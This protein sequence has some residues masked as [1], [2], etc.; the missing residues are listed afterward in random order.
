MKEN[1]YPARNVN[2]WII[3]FNEGREK[4]NEKTK[5]MVEKRKKQK[6]R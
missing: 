6:K 2:I 4:F 3:T 5:V 1:I